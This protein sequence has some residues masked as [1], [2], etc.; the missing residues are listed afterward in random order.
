MRFA[1]LA[2][3]LLTAAPAFADPP[4]D[5][6]ANGQT[7]NNSGS[8]TA[9]ADPLA[10]ARPESQNCRQLI[11]RA[12]GLTAPSNPGRADEA[13]REMRYAYDALA[14]GDEHACKRHAIKA[15]EDRMP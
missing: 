15:M 2:M 7:P 1:I 12:N 14:D 5:Y 11:A 6:M 4:A 9:P 13:R 3:A 10:G 8:G